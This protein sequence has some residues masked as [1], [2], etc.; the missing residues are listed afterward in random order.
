MILP[1]QFGIIPKVV[2][3]E[4]SPMAAIRSNLRRI[5]WHCRISQVCRGFPSQEFAVFVNFLMRRQV[6]KIKMAESLKAV[7]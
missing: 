2:G 6:R 3:F 4:I 7:E 5:S 1:C